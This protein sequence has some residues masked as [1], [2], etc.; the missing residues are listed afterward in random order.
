MY[1]R[2]HLGKREERPGFVLKGE[3]CIASDELLAHMGRWLIKLAM[4]WL[5][6][7]DIVR[8]APLPPGPK[9]IAPNHP[10]TTDP[11]LILPLVREPMSILIDER[12]FKVPIFGQV[13]TQSG[14]VPVVPG[15]GHAAYETALRLLESG[16]NIGIFPEGAISPLEGG[17]HS[18][19]TGAARLALRTGAPIIPVG[20]GLKRERIRLIETEIEGR[21]EVGTWYLNGPYAMTVGEPLYLRGDVEDH[22]YVREASAQ[23]MQCIVDLAHDSAL[24]MST[25]DS[26][27]AGYI[28]L[29]QMNMLARAQ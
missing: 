9:I 4:P 12:L 24:R 17:V 27:D 20:I 29:P 3:F 8:R 6:K 28:G 25:T 1:A 26:P 11:F 18:P 16:H 23:V 14:H 21:L 2:Y 15:N 10:S 5:F 19:R 22:A 13:L 7:M